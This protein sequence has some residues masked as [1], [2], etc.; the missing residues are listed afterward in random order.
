MAAKNSCSRFP[1]PK[2]CRGRLMRSNRTTTN[3]RLSVRWRTNCVYMPMKMYMK[4]LDI[5]WLWW[6]KRRKISG[7]CWIKTINFG[8]F[9]YNPWYKCKVIWMF[10]TLHFRCYI[11]DHCAKKAKIQP[12]LPNNATIALKVMWLFN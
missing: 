7:K 9:N 4:R 8:R 1:K 11:R 6:K 2:A 10:N 5:E 3:C 12:S